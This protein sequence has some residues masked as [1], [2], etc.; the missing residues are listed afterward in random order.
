VA[1][2]RGVREQLILTQKKWEGRSKERPF[3][4]AE[5]PFRMEARITMMLGF[6]PIGATA[7]GEIAQDLSARIRNGAETIKLS[8]SGTIIPE[9]RIEDWLRCH[10]DTSIRRSRAGRYRN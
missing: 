6:G 8:V 5:Q 10:P 1:A 2:R 3:L 9:K 4:N 7:I